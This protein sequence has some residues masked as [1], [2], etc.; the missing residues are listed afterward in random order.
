MGYIL[1]SVLGA[2]VIGVIFF[3]IAVNLSE[4]LAMPLVYIGAA[5]VILVLVFGADK[6]ITSTPEGYSVSE[7]VLLEEIEMIPLNE[8]TILKDVEGEVYLVDSGEDYYTFYY[9]TES[10]FATN[11]E[12]T[13]SSKRVLRSATIIETEDSKA[14]YQVYE[15]KYKG[16]PS[17]MSFAIKSYEEKEYVLRI[18]QNSIVQ[19]FEATY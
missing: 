17:F 9:E 12:K 7:P 5:V 15:Y 8:I 18:P 13:Y 16:I 11:Q 3:I 6:G 10:K 4:D 1:L 19:Q 2:M 14:L